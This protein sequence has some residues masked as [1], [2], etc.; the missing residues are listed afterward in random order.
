[1]PESEKYIKVINTSSDNTK[2]F[3]A[4]HP[5]D[6]VVTKAVNVCGKRRLENL[7][8]HTGLTG[9]KYG[10]SSVEESIDDWKNLLNE[11]ILFACGIEGEG[12]LSIGRLANTTADVVLMALIDLY[13]AL[14]DLGFKEVRLHESH[15]QTAAI[16]PELRGRGWQV[17]LRE[18][19]LLL[20]PP[21]ADIPINIM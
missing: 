9:G 17:E 2:V 8:I 12:L 14:G 21:L 11:I 5:T 16:V 7:Q 6:I 13:Q 19:I 18:N 20:V 3:L 10:T 1:M 4:N 15:L